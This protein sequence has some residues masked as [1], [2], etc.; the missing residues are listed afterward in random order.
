MQSSDSAIK[1]ENLGKCFRVYD[2][3]IDRIKQVISTGKKR[4]YREFWALQNV[5]FEAKKGE[6][7]GIIGRNGS[8]KS[9]LLQILC[10]TLTPTTGSITTHGRIAAL[11]ELGA[12]FN[13]EFTGRENVFLNGAI[14]GFN[15]RE[16]ENLFDEIEAFADIGNFIDQPVKKYSSGMFVRL[17]F[18]VQACV[19]P[20]ILIVDEALSVGDVFFQ[21]KCARYIQKLQNQG[22]TIF[23]VSHDLGIIRDLCKNTLY[24]K[25][26]N[27]VYF[28][29][30]AEAV[31][32]Y[33]IDNTKVNDQL[34]TVIP[35]LPTATNEPC[36]L[37]EKFKKTACWINE[38]SDSAVLKEAKLIAVSVLDDTNSAST[39]IKMTKPMKIQIL[40]Q[41]FIKHPIHGSVILR[42]RFDHLIHGSGSFSTNDTPPILKIG[43]YSI[44]EIEIGCMIEPGEYTF[45]V[46]IAH[47]IYSIPET[48]KIIEESPWLGPIT[49]TWDFENEKAPW[50]GM[51]GLPV[52]SRFIS[53]NS[54]DANTYVE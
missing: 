8:G 41:S 46:A 3:N 13:P 19:N 16:M 1:V 31:R 33:Y 26:G 43:E 7:I 29:P 50:F 4:Y 17:A 38:D 23:F 35:E 54:Q 27:A 47:P 5:S 18:A 11:L 36:D 34:A 25:E 32:K 9:T 42:N 48:G 28:G 15:R 10:R 6:S 39:K 30:S 51:F 45:M 14:L 21:Q 44:Y 22:T 49:I 12:G 20:D 52:K 53:L 24:L 37:I 2:K 40:Y